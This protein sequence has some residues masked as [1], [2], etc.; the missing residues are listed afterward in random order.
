MN[1]TDPI[2]I[3]PA[4]AHRA[5]P[6]RTPATLLLALC[7]SLGLTTQLA[8]Q[9]TPTTSVAFTIIGK[10]TN[11]AKAGERLRLVISYRPRS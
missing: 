3:A 9:T 2:T 8:A 1:H 5:A 4:C 11:Y 6:M 7:L 10:G